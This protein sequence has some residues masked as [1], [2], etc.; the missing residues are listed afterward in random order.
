MHHE[1]A[2]ALMITL[3]FFG[4]MIPTCAVIGWWMGR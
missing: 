2:I 3:G 1:L 4:V